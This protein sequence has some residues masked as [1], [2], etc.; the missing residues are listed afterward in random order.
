MLVS[1]LLSCLFFGLISMILPSGRKTE[2][3]YVLLISVLIL[4]V[5]SH[6]G[7]MN[8]SLPQ[9]ED[10]SIETPDLFP[11]S[12]ALQTAVSNYVFSLTGQM[13]LS[14]ESDL[15][16]QENVYE[17][18]WIRVVI[19]SGKEWEVQ[20]ALQKYFSFQGFTVVRED[21]DGSHQDFHLFSEESLDDYS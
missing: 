11:E 10:V 5:G 16:C 13:P 12:V 19:R 14:V 1:L 15:K 7:K 20:D 6:L 9:T 18:T 4:S 8:F 17:L 2:W 21:F 3:I